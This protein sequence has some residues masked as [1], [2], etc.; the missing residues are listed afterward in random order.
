MFNFRI[1]LRYSSSCRTIWSR[2]RYLQNPRYQRYYPWTNRQS[3]PAGDTFGYQATYDGT[4]RWMYSSQLDDAGFVGTAWG[5][6]SVTTD[7]FLYPSVGAMAA[8]GNTYPPY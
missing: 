3:G 5:G 6:F 2:L 1:E 4:N 8:Y 7:I